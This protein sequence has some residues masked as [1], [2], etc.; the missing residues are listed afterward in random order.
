MGIV[1]VFVS[2]SGAAATAVVGF[3]RDGSGG[4][5]CSGDDTKRQM[6]V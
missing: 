4:R 5:I 6:T 3:E 1:L 2:G